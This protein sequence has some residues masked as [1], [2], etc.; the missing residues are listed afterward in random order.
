[1]ARKGDSGLVFRSL[2][3]VFRP[4]HLFCG[5]HFSVSTKSGKGDFGP[6]FGP[7]LGFPLY[8]GGPLFSVRTYFGS[9][10]YTITTAVV[11]YTIT[12]AVGAARVRFSGLLQTLYN[13]S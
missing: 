5:P 12:M 4:H 11:V 1:M 13:Y 10:F 8:C 7:L 3:T 6:A 9:L 2:G